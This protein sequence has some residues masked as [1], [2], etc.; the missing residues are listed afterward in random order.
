MPK[1]IIDK[2][3][4][5]KLGFEDYREFAIALGGWALRTDF[6]YFEKVYT[7]SFERLVKTF[8]RERND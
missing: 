3:Y 6:T 7:S 5:K 2:A 1:L 4:L 8:E